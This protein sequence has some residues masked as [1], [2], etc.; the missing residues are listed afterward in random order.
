[1][2][3]FRNLLGGGGMGLGGVTPGTVSFG[4][5]GIALLGRSYI[6]SS[7]SKLHGRNR[8]CDLWLTGVVIIGQH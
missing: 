7:W 3:R 1:M 5:A 6:P 4:S 2:E 8:L